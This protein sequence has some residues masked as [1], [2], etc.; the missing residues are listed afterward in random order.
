MRKSILNWY[1]YKCGVT[2]SGDIL[3]TRF[4]KRKDTFHIN[5]LIINLRLHS[6][7]NSFYFEGFHI[8]YYF[9]DNVFTFKIILFF[10]NTF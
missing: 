2:W 6:N 9:Y 3:Q 7:E 10:G 1:R 4:I 5:Q 8:K